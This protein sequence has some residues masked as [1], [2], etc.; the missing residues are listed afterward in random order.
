MERISRVAVTIVT[1]NS[2]RFIRQCLESVLAQVPAPD[3]VVVVDNA[4]GDGTR[5]I[6]QEFESRLHVIYNSDNRGF[7]GGHNQAISYTTSQWVFVLNPDVRLSPD[8]LVRL[9]GAGEA[10]RSV[11]TVC[12]KLLAME[13]DLRVPL[14]P[15]LDSTGI[16]FTP[17]MR[18]FDRGSKEPDTGQYDGPEYVFGATGA[19]ALYRREMIADISIGGE[20]FDEDFFVYREDA[21][22]AWRA[23]LLGWK[24][25]Y[26]PTAVGYHVRSVLPS[27]RRGVAAAVNM[28]SVK[29][30]W[31]L[32]IK[33]AT[34]D[35]YR[36]HWWA[37]AARDVVIIGACVLREWTS[38]RAFPMVLRNVPKMLAKRRAIMQRRRVSDEY[39]AAWFSDKPKSFPA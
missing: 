22:V 30:R 15:V 23:Q 29:N 21:D 24:C 19:A 35:L 9:Q 3:E 14:R 25:L 16:Y 12:G 20:F 2:A 28:H 33:N 36:R 27:N 1:Y 4:S 13:P 18:H 26:V 34:G 5:A 31:Y 11:G 37:M 6:L 32:R 7:A 17:A 8:F 10:D 39:I 38:L